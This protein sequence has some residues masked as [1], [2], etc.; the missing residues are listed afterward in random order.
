L[1]SISSLQIKGIIFNYLTG[2]YVLR[3]FGL[4]IAVNYLR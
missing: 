1:K 2:K 3:K 4:W